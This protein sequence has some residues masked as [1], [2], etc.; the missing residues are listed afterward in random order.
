MC[1]CAAGQSAPGPFI[2]CDYV[3][4]ELLPPPVW[5]KVWFKKLYLIFFFRK[6]QYMIFEVECVKIFLSLLIVTCWNKLLYDIRE[7]IFKS[8]NY[9]YIKAIEC[10]WVSLYVCLFVPL[11]HR[12]REI[13]RYDFPWVA[14]GFRLKKLPDSTNCLPENRKNA[15]VTGDNPPYH[16]ILL[17]SHNNPVM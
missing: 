13:L 2:Y 7:Q 3:D 17:I 10:Q 6:D 1:A 8:I 9:H 14:D 4:I 12:N 15:K 11:L 5:K 16:R